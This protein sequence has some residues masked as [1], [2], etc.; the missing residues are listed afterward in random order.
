MTGL[1]HI[2]GVIEDDDSVRGALHRLFRKAGFTVSL[3]ATAEDYFADP[4]RGAAECL[5]IDV[6]LPGICGLELLERVRSESTTYVAAIVISA[7]DDEL[8][9]KRAAEA[10]AFEF[11]RKPFDNRQLEDA[12]SQALGLTMP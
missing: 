1:G 5:V 6:C 2:V 4:S 11:F 3:F 8:V 10:G 12:V 7:H 9:R